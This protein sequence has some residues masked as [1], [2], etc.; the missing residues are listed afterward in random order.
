MRIRTRLALGPLVA[1]AL[2]MGLGVAG[3]G[4]SNGDSGIATAGSPGATPSGAG[5]SG[6]SDQ[7]LALKFAQCMRAQGINMPDPQ[8]GGG[9]AIKIPEGVDPKKADAAMQKCRQYLPS[10]GDRA[11]SDPQQ[12]AQQR[13]FSQCMRANGVPNFPDP[14]A[15]GNIKAD[16]STLGIDPKGEK[17]KKAERACAQ[18]QTAPSGAPSGVA[19]TM[20]KQ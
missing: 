13:K 11:Q 20:T 10:G 8:S 17:F 1:M 2:A 18:Y 12:V 15:N 6:L 3:C 14:D 5:T 19:Q 16:A 7:E 4:G 9:L